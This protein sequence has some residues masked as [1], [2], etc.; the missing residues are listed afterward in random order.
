MAG[1]SPHL[2]IGILGAIA[3]EKLA[4]VA[5]G[6]AHELCARFLWCWPEPAPG[7]TL[8]PAPTDNAR[9]LAALRRIVALDLTTEDGACEPRIGLSVTAAELFEAFVRTMKDRALA[10]FGGMGDVLRK[11]PGHCLRLAAT[12]SVLDWS[13]ASSKQE[14]R[15]FQ[16]EHVE[17]AA[18][19]VENYSWRWR[20]A[21]SARQRSRRPSCRP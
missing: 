10:S 12:L 9:E 5:Q 1:Q 18:R 16:R 13:L 2:T 7:S 20:S 4:K 11:A 19:L 15:K 17:R 21:H 6:A 14:P 8:A 3:P